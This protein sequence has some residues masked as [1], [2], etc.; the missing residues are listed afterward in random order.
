[1]QNENIMSILNTV[2]L[3]EEDAGCVLSLANS[4]DIS[5]QSYAERIRAI[6]NKERASSLTETLKY[7]DRLGKAGLQLTQALHGILQRVSA[8]N[9]MPE[10]SESGNPLANFV[11]VVGQSVTK[12]INSRKLTELVSELGKHIDCIQRTNANS[13]ALCAELNDDTHELSVLIAAGYVVLQRKHR[14]VAIIREHGLDK[15]RVEAIE[16]DMLRMTKYLADINTMRS[17]IVETRVVL[18]DILDG[19]LQN[20]AIIR[21]THKVLCGKFSNT[22]ARLV[23]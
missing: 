1:M 18:A 10:T 3:G 16:D 13:K 6:S 15:Q 5:S 21:N 8:E 20:E 22:K 17:V 12:E 19:M 4:V 9:N 11:N 23:C 14:E 7:A 2:G